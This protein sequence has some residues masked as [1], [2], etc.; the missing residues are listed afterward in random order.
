MSPD[1][2]VARIQQNPND[3]AAWET[4]YQYMHARLVA[5]VSSLLFT[6]NQSASE[7]APDIVHDVV[8]AFWERWPSLKS[9][10]SNSS[11]AYNY[12]KT[13]SR[14]LLVDRYRHDQSARP[15]LDFLTL[16]FGQA[17]DP[18]KEVVHEILVKEVIERLPEGC[19]SILKSYVDTGLS[20]A[21][22]ADR[23]G[24]SPSAFYTK[25]YRCLDK[26][27]HLILRSRAQD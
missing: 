23:E 9:T 10:I 5:Y 7:T 25:W 17:P 16:K 27:R 26:A 22:M 8:C 1:D 13:A 6:F 14:N 19:G 4:I 15:L 2:A 18:E 12:M 24:A 20:L 21:E 11:A 3:A